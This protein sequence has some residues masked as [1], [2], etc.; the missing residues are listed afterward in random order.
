[1]LFRSDLAGLVSATLEGLTDP[2]PV[3][4]FSDQTRNKPAESKFKGHFATGIAHP[5]AANCR[6]G[7]V[8]GSTGSFV[9]RRV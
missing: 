3:L 9:L 7:V 5:D 8:L 1:M 4:N 2:V 6:S